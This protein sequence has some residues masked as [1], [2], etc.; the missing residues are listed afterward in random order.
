MAEIK[1]EGYEA[2]SKHKSSQKYSKSNSFLANIITNA[3]SFPLV[4]YIVF[5]LKA[6][7]SA[8]RMAKFTHTSGRCKITRIP[9]SSCPSTSSNPDQCLLPARLAEI[10]SDSQKC[11]NVWYFLIYL[12]ITY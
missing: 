10:Y 12:K 6:G 9:R 2:Y 7:H 4:N 3:L 11:P 5:F 1:D 8:H